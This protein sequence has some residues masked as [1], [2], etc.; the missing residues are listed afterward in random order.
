MYILPLRGSRRLNIP[1]TGKAT[2]I[3]FGEFCSIESG[4]IDGTYVLLDLTDLMLQAG[5]RVLPPAMGVRQP[6]QV[7]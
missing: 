6:Y 2:R 5:F 7:Q 4:K 1:K 3:R